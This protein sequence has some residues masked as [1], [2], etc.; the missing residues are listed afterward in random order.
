MGKGL[1][2]SSTKSEVSNPQSEIRNP[3]SAMASVQKTKIMID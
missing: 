3:K 1:E 2:V